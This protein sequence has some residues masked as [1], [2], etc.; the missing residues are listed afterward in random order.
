MADFAGRPAEAADHVRQ[1]D[2]P[3]LVVVQRHDR[4]ER[5]ELRV[6]EN[7]PRVVDRGNRCL[8][9]VER[10]QHFSPRTLSDP[11]C[12]SRIDL[13][14][15]LRAPGAG[16]EPRLCCQVCSADEDQDTLGDRGGTGRH[17][18]PESVAGPVDVARRVVARAVA[19]TRLDL[20]QQ[21]VGGDLW[22]EQRQQRLDERGVDDLSL[23]RRLACTEGDHDR[24]RGGEAGDAVG[25]SKRRQERRAVGLPVQR[26]ESAHRLG[27]RAEARPAG[28]RPRLAE[29]AHPREHEPRIDG[30]ELVPAEPPALQRPR[31][32]V[33]EHDV[34]A[35]RE[36]EEDSLPF[37]PGEIERDEAL[38]AGQ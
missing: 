6:G 14:D 17:R 19:G 5:S 11:G 7:V 4:P 29:A 38:V 25:E 31:P 24:E 10:R 37:G 32:E 35:F 36:P 22:A 33:L 13:L 20:P 8:S 9:R 27:E 18:H 1:L 16:S 30:R 21:V 15:M 34:G 26:C 3:E 23:A 2:R 12:D 28:I